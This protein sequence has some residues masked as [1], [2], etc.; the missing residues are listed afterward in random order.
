MKSKIAAAFLN[1]KSI[2]V[3]SHAGIDGDSAGGAIA[4]LQ[5]GRAAGKDVFYV[6]SEPI[7]DWLSFIPGAELL[8]ESFAEDR[9]FDLGFIIDTSGTDRVGAAW[10]LFS[11]LPSLVCVDHH[12]GDSGCAAVSWIDSTAA[13]VTVMI[14]ELLG[15]AGIPI[16]Y[17]LAVPLYVGLFTDTFSFQQTN[18]D[19]RAMEWGAR[20][21]GAGVRPFEIATAILEN[22][23][24]TA[25]RL[26]GRAGSRAVV[27]NGVCWSTLFRADY[28][29]L[30]A[31]DADTEGVIGLLRSV[32]GAKVAIVF[33]EQ[34]GGRIKVNFR[35]KDS[36]DVAAVAAQFGG[37]GHRAAAGCTVTGSLDDVR[38][39][40]LAA[41]K[42]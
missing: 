20:F 40:V 7:P 21:I 11:K 23:T 22:R 34:E 3:T 36:T 29:E 12:K 5:A 41:F 26:S 31:T 16:T 38:T 25:V 1:A 10:R 33:K 15:E 13:S 37:G 8:R 39:R 42:S 24:L 4:L 30:G 18:T 28:E 32:G 6:N 2:L 27:E 17:D 19:V 14:A 35:S 9:H